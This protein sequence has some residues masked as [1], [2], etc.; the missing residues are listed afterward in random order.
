MRRAP[1]DGFD[2]GDYLSHPSSLPERFDWEGDDDLREP[3]EPA[4]V[5]HG[6]GVIVPS[7]SALTNEQRERI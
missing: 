2:M 3:D 6:F 4:E 5:E 7:S 1:F